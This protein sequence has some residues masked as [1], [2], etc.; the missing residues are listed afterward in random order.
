MLRANNVAMEELHLE[1]KET[2]IKREFEERERGLQNLRREVEEQERYLEEK[3]RQIEEEKRSL[4]E[5]VMSQEGEEEGD[6]RQQN[7]LVAIQLCIVT[8]GAG[9]SEK[10]SDKQQLHLD[11]VEKGLKSL[12]SP[13][14]TI[15]LLDFPS[16]CLT[17]RQDK[18]CN[19]RDR[20]EYSLL[21]GNGGILGIN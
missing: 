3:I 12:I 13:K 19:P 21:E 8:P 10:S 20:V 18:E 2:K 1:R 7:H 5:G 9:H 14:L 16:K 11:T 6:R 17:L 4:I 15:F